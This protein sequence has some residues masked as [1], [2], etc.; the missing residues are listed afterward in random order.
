MPDIEG[1][2]R[3]GSAVVAARG[4]LCLTSPHA[5]PPQISA[6]A[7]LTSDGMDETQT[8]V[9]TTMTVGDSVFLLAQGTDLPDLKRRIEAAVQTPGRFVDVVVV[10]N[11]AA[12][13]LMF[14]GIRVVFAIETVQ[15]DNRD[16]GDELTPYGGMFDF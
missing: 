15:F 1:H 11:R 9:R 10:G 14:S 6:G 8:M 16:T 4:S 5:Q 7:R 3:D 12:S 13:V 2:C